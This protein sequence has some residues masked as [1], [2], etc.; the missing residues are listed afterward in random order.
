MSNIKML[1]EKDEEEVEVSWED[2]QK[3]NAFSKLNAKTDDLEEQYEKLKQEKEYLDDLSM[4][5]ELADDDEPVRYKIGDAF[6]HMPLDKALERITSDSEKVS[7]DLE[8]LKSQMDNVQ[9]QMAELKKALYGK[10]GTSINL[11]KD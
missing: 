7:A 4:E 8:E 11:E 10:F 2:Q 3:I 9:D 1:N 5:L 6:V